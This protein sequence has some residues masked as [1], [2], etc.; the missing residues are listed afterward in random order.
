MVAAVSPEL[1][2]QAV[3]QAVA[4]AAQQ[5]QEAA[6]Q[7]HQEIETLRTQLQDAAQTVPQPQEMHTSLVDTRLLGKPESFDGGIG[8]KDWSVIFRS[9]ACACSAPLG[10]LLERTERSAGPMLN[11]F[12]AC[13]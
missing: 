13:W 5:W 6:A 9:F 8:W 7:M 4:E 10:L 11:S 1:L 3:Q 12:T 2:Q